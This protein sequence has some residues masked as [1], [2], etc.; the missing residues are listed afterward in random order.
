MSVSEYEGGGASASNLDKL[1]I[2]KL[3]DDI[4][5]LKT[6]LDIT[7]RERDD[8]SRELREQEACNR[9]IKNDQILFETKI[10]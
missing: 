1:E 3:K 5:N 10:G 6:K 7:V 4:E 9:T 2:K 8:N